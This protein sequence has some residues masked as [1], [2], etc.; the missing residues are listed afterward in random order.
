MKPYRD[1]GTRWI[2][3]AQKVA[4]LRSMNRFQPLGFACLCALTLGAAGC[5]STA[6]TVRDGWRESPTG[7][8]VR[9]DIEPNEYFGAIQRANE[10]A[11]HRQQ[12]E[13][14]IRNERVFNTKTERFEHLPKDHPRVWNPKTNRWEYTPV[15]DRERP[16]PL[17]ED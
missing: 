7:S 9:G 5:S 10:E 8:L 12:F 4:F 6:E 1:A 11:N 2:A 14:N 16:R 13:A 15:D 3:I 17:I